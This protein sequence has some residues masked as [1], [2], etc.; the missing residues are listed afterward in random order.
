MKR[1]IYL[2]CFLALTFSQRIAKAQDVYILIADGA[3]GGTLA[4]FDLADP[5]TISTPTTIGSFTTSGFVTG[6]A[7]GDGRIFMATNEASNF[8][9]ELDMT[10]GA[11]TSIG[12]SGL[13]AGD[14]I[15]DLAWDFANARLLGLGVN[16]LASDP[17]IYEID[18]STGVANKIG[19]ITGTGQGAVSL[20]ADPGNG[21]VYIHDIVDDRWYR[22]D[23]P[24]FT[25]STALAP[26]P[27]DTNFG[28]GGE[29][30]VDG[31]LYH[32]A[33]NSGTFDGELWEIDKTDGSAVTQL[34]T[35]GGPGS[36]TQVSDAFTFFPTFDFDARA[37]SISLETC[38]PQYTELS[39]E[40]RNA[41]NQAFTGFQV[42]YV[43]DGGDPVVEDVSGVT[44]APFTSYTHTFETRLDLSDGN[45]HVI[46]VFVTMAIDENSLNDA[47]IGTI[48]NAVASS[49][50]LGAAPGIVL[51]EDFE[52]GVGDCSDIEFLPECWETTSEDLPSMVSVG[53]T[54][55]YGSAGLACVDDGFWFTPDPHTNFIS[56]NDDFIVAADNDNERLNTPSLSFATIPM[57]DPI[58]LSYSAHID[59]FGGAFAQIEVSTDGGTTWNV[60]AGVPVTTAST[61]GDGT[62]QDNIMVDLSAYAGESDVIISFRYNDTGIWANGVGFDDI[63]VTSPNYTPP[64]GNVTSTNVTTP[65]VEE[66]YVPQGTPHHILYVAKFE[67]LQDVFAL[68]DFVVKTNGSYLPS[69]INIQGDTLGFRLWWSRDSILGPGDIFLGRQPALQSG[70]LLAF[71][72]LGNPFMPFMNNPEDAYVY[73]T[74]D[75]ADDAVDNRTI[76]IEDL[77]ITSFGGSCGAVFGNA[78]VLNPINGER[79]IIGA[80]PIIPQEIFMAD[81]FTP[82]GDGNND[83]FTITGGGAINTEGFGLKIF[84]RNGSIV[85]ET[86]NLKEA[87]TTGW[88]GKIDGEDA[89][90]GVYLW[91]LEGTYLNG[92]RLT[93][94]GKPTG[95]TRLLR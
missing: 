50:S 87:V 5:A 74:V 70:S 23:A 27:F 80:P 93:F 32:A 41:G 65:L 60:E 22:A 81:L 76:W 91:S 51:S 31:V 30:F 77:S 12:G 58:T 14:Q 54:Y 53:E 59:G 9:F 40:V 10:T 46:D 13:D 34:G 85:Y 7:G 47:L 44:L 57:G 67:Y 16:F 17:N 20:A 88:D 90:N 95:V 49:G 71:T 21:D 64:A 73:L 56:I 66:A 36:T 8:L 2:L 69:D 82:N 94:D 72:C 55:L 6:L 45:D 29:F 1:I 63:E 37:A 89:P 25:T 43:L 68:G 52:G 42:G 48:V 78:E 33:F 35:F 26:L 75:I 92:E 15:Q 61:T 38:S 28:Q 86:N 4:T 84:D 18:M 24:G 19:T 11:A 3:T 39:F 62:W 79:Q 83:N